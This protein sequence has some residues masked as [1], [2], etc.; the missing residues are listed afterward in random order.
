MAQ[1]RKWKHVT[2]H[3]ES[4][5]D[6]TTSKKKDWFF[7]IMVKCWYVYKKVC[8][9]FARAQK[10]CIL[11]FYLPG[12]RIFPKTPP[13]FSHHCSHGE[14]FTVQR[15]KHRCKACVRTAVT[16]GANS[17]ETIQRDVSPATTFRISV[18]LIYNLE[19]LNSTVYVFGNRF[20]YKLKIIVITWS[21]QSSKWLFSFWLRSLEEILFSTG[22]N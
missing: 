10:Q 2:T 20:R 6:C 19:I 13:W 18:V 11:S 7:G 22:L 16:S 15:C 3:S 9:S 4:S 5:S 1:S 21:F 8:C 17:R 12:P 14:V